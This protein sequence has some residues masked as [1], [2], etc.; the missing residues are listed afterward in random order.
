MTDGSCSQ[1]EIKDKGEALLLPP[2]DA[3]ESH[4]EDFTV[5]ACSLASVEAEIPWA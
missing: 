3:A 4:G 5:T 2:R 1:K